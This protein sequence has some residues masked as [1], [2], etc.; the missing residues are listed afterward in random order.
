MNLCG[1]GCILFESGPHSG[2]KVEGSFFGT[3]VF[4]TLR[5]PTDPYAENVAVLG[6]QS[7]VT[8]GGTTPAA[9]NLFASCPSG[10]FA[11]GPVSTLVI[12]GNLFG[13]AATGA[14]FTNGACTADEGGV[15][16]LA[17]PDTSGI[18]IGGPG[19]GAGNVI[20]GNSHGVMVRNRG[21]VIQG[22]LIGTDVSG[23]TGRFLAGWGLDLGYL[24]GTSTTSTNCIVGGSG[25][26][27]GNVFG[28]S[29]GIAVSGSGHILQGNFIGTDRTGTNDLGNRGPGILVGAA[30]N[31]LIGGVG[32]GEANTIAFNAGHFSSGGIGFQGGDEST[33]SGVT[34]RGNR[35]YKNRHPASGLP[36]GL[37]IDLGN[38]GGVTPND[39][40]D[41]DVGDNN[42]QNFPNI[43]SVVSEAAPGGGGTRVT[44]RLASTAFTTFDLDFYA[45]GCAPFSRAFTQA[46]NHLGSTQVTTDA[47][48]YAAFHVLLPVQIDPGDRVAATATDPIGNTSELSQSIVISSTP[49]AGDAAGG[50][51]V[52]V[53]GM[54]FEPGA[55][56]TVGGTPATIVANDVNELEITAPALA[57]GTANDISVVNP[58]GLAGTLPNGWIA[59]FVDVPPGHLFEPFVGRL[60]RNGLTAGCAPGLFCVDDPVTR[61]QMSVFLLLSK[62]GICYLPPDCTAPTFNDV[63]CASVYARWIEELVLRLVT[64]GCGANNYCPNDPVTREQMAV[65]LL[66]TLYGPN[67]TPPACTSAPFNDVPCSNP[68]APWII[69]LVR[70]S[71]TAGCGGGNYCPAESVTRGQM[72]VFLSTTFQ[73]PP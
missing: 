22:N 62:E 69:T 10:I 49:Q 57:P 29:R 54:Q 65:F 12:Q 5:F 18:L 9:R 8:I 71:I 72:S 32:P 67:Y 24:F 38:S 36:G 1:R 34:M 23:T 20:A 4:G 51:T 70:I 42:L 41:G 14:A 19:P 52:I 45:D 50:G 37:A 73:L 53:R 25:V 3:N 58:S 15:A 6:G 7:N 60:T 27:E 26:G 33:A 68:F 64:A 21:T 11:I 40:G 47:T 59:R 39:T 31:I 2:N 30:T 61:E 43:D 17:G 35:I 13:L 55:T 48:G 66:R 44:G 46:E 63:P 56:V 28:D 16:I